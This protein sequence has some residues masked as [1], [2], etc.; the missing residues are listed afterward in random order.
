MVEGAPPLSGRTGRR[1]WSNIFCAKVM[2]AR[3]RAG[4]PADL[5][6]VSC[7]IPE[8]PRERGGERSGARG[9]VRRK[10]GKEERRKGRGKME[11]R[12]RGVEKKSGGDEERVGGAEEEP[13]RSRGGAEKT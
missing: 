11:R 13:R 12:S 10:R 1:K 3:A 8:G 9:V 6:H 2:C 7:L 4:W 5:A